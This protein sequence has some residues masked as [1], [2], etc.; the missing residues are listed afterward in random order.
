MPLYVINLAVMT[1]QIIVT[2]VNFRPLKVSP[3]TPII[4]P[5]LAF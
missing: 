4:L 3:K 5:K 1:T 2:Y